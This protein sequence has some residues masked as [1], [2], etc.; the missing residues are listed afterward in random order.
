MASVV[1]VG[2]TVGISLNAIDF[3]RAALRSVLKIPLGCAYIQ[4]KKWKRQG[5][6]FQRYLQTLC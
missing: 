4:D 2:A 5:E 3:G 1:N 6:E